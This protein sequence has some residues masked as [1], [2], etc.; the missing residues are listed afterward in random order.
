MNCSNF[1]SGGM[2]YLRSAHRTRQSA[3]NARSMVRNTDRM[4]YAMC[5]A[6][7][8]INAYAPSTY[9]TAKLNR[10]PIAPQAAVIPRLT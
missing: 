2:S 4:T 7:V 10:R 9:G 5:H 1:V 8:C 6:C 3:V